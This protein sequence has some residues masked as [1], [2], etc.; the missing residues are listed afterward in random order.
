MRGK[1]TT[2][3]A[4]NPTPPGWGKTG[5]V[6]PRMDPPSGAKT[7]RKGRGPEAIEIPP[8]PEASWVFDQPP[9]AR[10]VW[11]GEGTRCSATYPPGLLERSVACEL[12]ER[13]WP[14]YPHSAQ[15]SSV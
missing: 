4:G 7:I 15:R 2:H 3:E 10:Y 6:T 5:V 8:A 9:P 1:V 13:H 11:R 12:V 14:D